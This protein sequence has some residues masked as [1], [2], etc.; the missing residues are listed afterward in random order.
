MSY[1]CIIAIYPL[2]I[3]I[4]CPL[5]RAAACAWEVRPGEAEFIGQS[6]DAKVREAPNWM[7]V[8]CTLTWGLWYLYIYI[9]MFFCWFSMIFFNFLLLY[10][11]HQKM[12]N[13]LFMTWWSTKDCPRKRNKHI[14]IYRYTHNFPPKERCW[15]KIPSKKKWQRRNWVCPCR[16]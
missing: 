16:G 4:D 7:R 1:C 2:L 11:K 3:T 6:A 9:Y 8:Y 10:M 14:H 12:A 15:R 13:Y 5:S